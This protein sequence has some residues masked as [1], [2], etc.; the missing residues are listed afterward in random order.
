MHGR[1]GCG[2]GAKARYKV[3]CQV[4]MYRHTY[5]RK[6]R[7]KETE[8]ERVIRRMGSEKEGVGRGEVRV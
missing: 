1:V 4:H 2:L 8:E 6:I 7:C 5:T 3:W